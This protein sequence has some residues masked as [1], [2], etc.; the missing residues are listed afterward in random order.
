[1]ST[2]RL[3]MGGD[4]FTLS[5]SH[6]YDGTVYTYEDTFEGQF[7]VVN[8]S[9]EGIIFDVYDVDED[10]NDILQGSDSGTWNELMERTR[11]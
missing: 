11:E 7:L 2:E 3:L 9:S 10:G 6:D 8:I 1:M 5:E 4:G